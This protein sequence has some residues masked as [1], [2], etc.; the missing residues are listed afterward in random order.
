MVLNQALIV[1]LWSFA[2]LSDPFGGFGTTTYSN[3][4]LKFLAY[5]IWPRTIAVPTAVP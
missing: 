2:K 3:I 4:P 5:P 1:K